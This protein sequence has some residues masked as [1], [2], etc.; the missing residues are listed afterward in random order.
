MPGSVLSAILIVLFASLMHGQSA[1]QA[2]HHQH[3]FSPTVASA[4]GVPQIDANALIPLLDAAG[5]RRAAVLSVAYILGDPRLRR[6]VKLHFANSRVD[7]HNREHVDR[8]RKLLAAANQHKM[9]IVAFRR[10]PLTEAEFRT[11]AGNVPQY[12]RT[13]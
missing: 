7:Y 2:D 8:V 5:I 10:L 4:E 1:P 12:M 13:P 9:A 11:I 6:G 3:L